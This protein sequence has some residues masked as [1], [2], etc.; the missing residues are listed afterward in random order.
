MLPCRL[1][2]LL[3]VLAPS[4]PACTSTTAQ[5][6]LPPLTT[7]P[8]VDLT[9]YMGVWYE[10]ASIPQRYQKGCMGT[11]ATYTLQQ[12]GQVEVVNACRKSAEPQA[13][14]QAVGRARVVPDSGDAKLEVS[15]FWPFWG[16]YWIV[17]LAD[18]YSFAV[19]GSPGRDSL[20]IL[21]RTPKLPGATTAGILRRL[22]E[23]N[24]D[25]QRLNWTVQP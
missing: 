6:H 1:L 22:V 5:Q 10:I 15:F 11:R 25:V 21:S 24:Y 13:Y 17:D 19:V 23:K 18:D 2:A 3:L 8:R 16:D 12:S 20:W 9:R 4:A 14:S 7:V